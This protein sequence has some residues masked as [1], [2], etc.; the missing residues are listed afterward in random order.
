MSNLLVKGTNAFV[1]MVFT[2]ENDS[3]GNPVTLNS[4]S[5]VTMKLGEETYSVNDVDSVLIIVDEL[6]L[7]LRA[8]NITTLSNGCYVP[9]VSVFSVDYPQGFPLNHKCNNVL[10]LVQICG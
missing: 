1:S 6:E 7:T 9:E 2:F 4:F 8:S 5:D 3:A 10:G